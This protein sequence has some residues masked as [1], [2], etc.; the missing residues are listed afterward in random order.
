MCINGV[1]QTHIT[2]DSKKEK[3]TVMKYQLII[4]LFSPLKPQSGQL[5]LQDFSPFPHPKP[6]TTLCSLF[7]F[8]FTKKQQRKKNIVEFCEWKENPGVVFFGVGV[9]RWFPLSCF[10]IVRVSGGAK[11]ACPDKCC[12]HSPRRRKKSGGAIGAECDSDE[13]IAGV[14]FLA[15]QR[16]RLSPLN[17][18]A[19]RMQKLEFR[20]WN[21]KRNDEVLENVGLKCVP[22]K[23][24][25]KATERKRDTENQQQK[26]Q[27]RTHFY[28][29]S[30][31]K[32]TVFLKSSYVYGGPR[33]EK[34]QYHHRT[35]IHL[36]F[37]F[38]KSPFVR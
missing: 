17:V 2:R 6:G 9:T 12:L 37:I 3:Y 28:S 14:V 1:A 29:T 32:C 35:T 30:Q 22:R 34:N 16:C 23:K 10:S 24:K 31:R 36:I 11:G 19:K 21:S 13:S 7:I 38:E 20:G 8:P 15:R 25:K 18:P 5:F 26:Q 27:A 4:K 33:K